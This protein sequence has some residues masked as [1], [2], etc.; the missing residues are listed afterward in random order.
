MKGKPFVIVRHDRF[1]Y[2]ACDTR[3][4]LDEAAKSL[5]KSMPLN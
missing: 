4:E 3:A 1:V 5:G 2:A